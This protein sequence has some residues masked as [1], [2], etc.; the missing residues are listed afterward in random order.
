MDSP[1]TNKPLFNISSLPAPVVQ[2]PMAGGPSTPELAAAVS[3]AGGLGFLAAGYKTASAVKAEIEATR[4][5][6]DSP[7]GVNVFVPQPSM[8]SPQAL[9]QYARSLAP[10]AERLGAALGDPRHDDDEWD[11]KLDVLLK[12][13]PAVASFTF[14]LPDPAVVAALRQRGVYV[15]S[16]VTS[17][18]EALRAVDAGVDALCVQGPEA[19]GHRGTFDPARRPENESLHGLLEELADLRVP[20]IAAGGITT[21]ADTQAALARGAVAVQAG[22]AFLRADEAG[23]KAPHRMALASGRFTATSVTRSFSGR[24]ARGL[25]NEFMRRH[26]G[27]APYGYPE[28]HHLTAPLRAAASAAGDPEYM[29]LWAGTG[30]KHTVDGPAAKILAALRP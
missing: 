10:E 18:P 16:T 25:H 1:A 26:D 28:I 6:T 22:T 2:A 21:A 3:T 23:T 13:A 17:R 24:N 30:F 7:F 29:S 27:D 5:L 4:R 14:D 11:A 12:E 9:D 20:L 19:G 8:I 15:I